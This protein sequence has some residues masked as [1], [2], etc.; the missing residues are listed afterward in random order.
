MVEDERRTRRTTSGSQNTSR[1]Q[2]DQRAREIARRKRMRA[3]RRR[4]R[5]LALIGLMLTIF[6][7]LCL[8]VGIFAWKRY[9]P[10]NEMYDLDG[11]YGITS[12]GQ[13]AIIVDNYIVNPEGLIED[14]KAYVRYE[15]VRDYI[16]N[17]FYWDSEEKSLLY[18]LPNDMISVQPDSKEYAVSKQTESGEYVILKLKDDVA[19]IALDFIKQHMDIEYEVYENPNRVSIITDWGEKMVSTFKK[20]TEVRALG[21]VK[22]QILSKVSK[23]DKVVVLEDE[24]DWKKVRTADGYIGYAKTSTLEKESIE[25]TS[26]DFKEQEYTSISKDYTINLVWDNVTN[27]VANEH[28]SEMLAD[29][30][31]ITTIAPTWFYVEDTSGKIDSIVSENYVYYCHE[32]GIEV[33]ATVRDFDGGIGSFEETLELL[34]STSQRTRMIN[35]LIEEVVDAGIDGINVDFENVSE[36]CGEH[37]IEFIRELSVRCRQ[38]GIVLSVDNYVPQGYNMQYNRKEQGIFADYVVIMGYDEY[39]AGSPEAGPVSSYS[40]VK[41]GIEETLKE[42][43]AEKI[44]SGIPF[45]SRLWTVGK[46]VDSIALGMEDAAAYVEAS[47]S[48][49]SW[50]DEVGAN[51]ATWNSPDGAVL[52]IWLEDEQSIESKLKLMKDN[53]LAGTAEWALGLEDPAIWSLIKSYCK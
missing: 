18:A 8:C 3:R 26:R 39:Y 23:G 49:A 29:T 35:Q 50:D 2:S 15:I 9:S 52:K 6:L 30:S 1:Q 48:S 4:R 34:K 51:Y 13:M 25:T 28:I 43:P 10:S 33:W 38:N 17:R 12:E 19:Y 44:I 31:G 16:S 22:S 11:Y 53:H 36:E 47:G 20:D 41:D 21:G 7:V 27:F 42:V 5:L 46:E 14:G 24:D 45:F 37:Y 32:K 40:Y